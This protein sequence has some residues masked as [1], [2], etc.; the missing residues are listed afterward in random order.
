MLRSKR[1]APLPDDFLAW[2]RAI[3]DSDPEIVR[4]QN[5]L[6]A[7]MFLRFLRSSSLRF[8]ICPPSFPSHSDGH[9][10]PPHLVRQLG[11][12]ASHQWCKPQLR[13]RWPRS[14]HF[15]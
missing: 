6:D 1:V 5:G 12:P 4:I 11:R 7:Y 10:S 8:L 13:S 14:L 9:H 2:P 3:W 15:W